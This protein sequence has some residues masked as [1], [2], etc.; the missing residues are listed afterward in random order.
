VLPPPPANDL[1]LF[2]MGDQALNLRGYE[3]LLDD[4]GHYT[5]LQEWRWEP[6]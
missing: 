1:Q 2:M 3:R 5:V 6:M 4:D